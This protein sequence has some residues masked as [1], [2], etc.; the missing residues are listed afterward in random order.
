ML[1]IWLVSTSAVV[2][3][4]IYSLTSSKANPDPHIPRPKKK[5]T[6]FW[7]SGK[8]SNAS[9]DGSVNAAS[10]LMK[11]CLLARNPPVRSPSSS[12]LAD[13]CMRVSASL[14]RL[15]TVS[16]ITML[17]ISR[18]RRASDCSVILAEVICSIERTRNRSSISQSRGFMPARGAIVAPAIGTCGYNLNRLMFLTLSSCCSRVSFK[19]IVRW[20]RF[21]ELG[22]SP[23]D[24]VC[25][26]M[27]VYW[28]VYVIWIYLLQMYLKF[29]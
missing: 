1:I 9:N 21:I 25:A 11:A 7:S 18:R 15:P 6:Y 27:L 28:F 3:A 24:D 10:D 22:F 17:L 23:Y 5:K 16:V 20:C 2:F 26:G 4:S 8:Y 14:M 12:N 19:W 29:Q 13:S